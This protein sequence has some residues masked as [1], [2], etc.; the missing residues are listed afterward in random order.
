MV[1]GTSYDTEPLGGLGG[2][3]IVQLMVPPGENLVDGTNTRLDDN[4]QFFAPGSTNEILGAGKRQLLAWRGFPDATGTFVDDAGNPTS[5]GNNEGDIRPA[6]TLMPVP[7]NAKSRVRSKWIDTGASQRRALTSVDNQPRGLITAG[8]AQVGPVF[9]FAG[10]DLSSVVAGYVDY[11]ALGSSVRIKY[12]VAVQ[13]TPLASLDTEASY[14]GAP[15]YRIDLGAAVL[16][17]ANRYV[18]YEAELLNNAGSVLQGYRILSHDADSMLVEASGG[19]IPSQASQVQV[20]A[21]FFKIVTDGSEGLGS[22]YQE[23]VTN[24]TPIP[25]ANVRI[26]FAFHQDP[27]PANILVGRF[28]ENSEQEF[29]RDLN[30]PALQAWIAANGAPRYVQWD[31]VFDMAYHPTNPALAQTLTPSTPRPQIEFLRLPFRF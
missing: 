31:V 23:S 27:D 11:E 6:P 20:R 3:G 10:L 4:I 21:K 25:Y 1:A 2:M 12:P 15:A 8:G 18:Q 16:G 28:P 13:P 24:S 26:G 14:L 7:F 19:L 5:I 9:E 30:D 17:Q 29:V 22:T